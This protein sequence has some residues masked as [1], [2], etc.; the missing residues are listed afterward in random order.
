LAEEV[1]AGSDHIEAVEEAVLGRTA[2][3]AA[4]A[5]AVEED[6]AGSRMVVEEKVGL[7]DNHH[8]N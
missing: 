3:A 5:A 6:A 1:L 4:A 7:V 8:R 2:A